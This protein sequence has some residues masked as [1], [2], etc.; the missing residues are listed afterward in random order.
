MVNSMKK[1]EISLKELV[2]ILFPEKLEER[3][4]EC[5]QLEYQFYESCSTSEVQFCY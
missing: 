5:N 2:N 4:L 3:V 1:H